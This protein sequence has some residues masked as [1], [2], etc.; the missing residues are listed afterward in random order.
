M[1]TG[2][3]ELAD[4]MGKWPVYGGSDVAMGEWPACVDLPWRMGRIRQ[5]CGD[6]PWLWEEWPACGDLP[7]RM[8]KFVRRV[9]VWEDRDTVWEMPRDMRTYAGTW[10]GR[11]AV[12][13]AKN[14]IKT[15]NIGTMGGLRTLHVFQKFLWE[16]WF[17]GRPLKCMGIIKN[18]I[19]QEAPDMACRLCENQGPPT[20]MG[21]PRYRIGIWPV[22]GNVRHA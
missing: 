10:G 2:F 1:K 22:Y 3:L 19:M 9:V 5:A 8:G 14:H 11:Q 16:L 6:L 20:C 13:G 7:K 12:W 18:M 21:K 4:R 15:G 17:S